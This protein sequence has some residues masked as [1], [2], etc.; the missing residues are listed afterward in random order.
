MRHCGQNR[1]SALQAPANIGDK[2]V[3]IPFLEGSTGASACPDYVPAVMRH[4]P[5]ALVVMVQY[6]VTVKDHASQIVQ[7]VLSLML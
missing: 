5:P 3:Y 4:T 7:Y 1:L 2:G 6:Q